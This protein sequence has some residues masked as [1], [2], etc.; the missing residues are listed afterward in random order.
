MVEKKEVYEALTSFSGVISMYKGEVKSLSNQDLI[1]DLLQAK[2]IKKV[3]S[4]KE[5]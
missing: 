2:Y 1:K 3:T 5:E 4:G